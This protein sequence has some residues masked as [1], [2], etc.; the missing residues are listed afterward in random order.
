MTELFDPISPALEQTL[1]RCAELVRRLGR[2]HHLAQDDVDEVFQEVRIR[3]WRALASGER[4][5]S[6]PASYVYRTAQS[7]AVDLIRRRRVRRE[8]GVDPNRSSGETALGA[9]P[10]PD[11]AVERSELIDALEQALDSLI[12]SRRP[13]VRMHLAGYS[14]EEIAGLLGWSEPKTRNL[15][16][17]GLADLRAA[18]I[19]R[20]F[21]PEAPA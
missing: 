13:V 4:I 9:D 8:E 7:A 11:R 17:R 20:G 6:V 14:L 15:L 12:P 10:G 21:G 18:L 2:R 5:G 19:E 1:S 16:Y 3:L